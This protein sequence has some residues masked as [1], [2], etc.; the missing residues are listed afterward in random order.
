M[1]TF[2]QDASANTPNG[3]GR[4]EKDKNRLPSREEIFEVLSN[5]RR[6]YTLH[7][8]KQLDEGSE[9]TLGEIATHVA[10]WEQG[11]EPSE[12]AYDDRKSVQT[13]LYQT[14]L[15]KLEEKN[16]IEY[17][18][19]SDRVTRRESADTIDFYLETVSNHELPWSYVF[20]GLS[21]TMLLLATGVAIDAYLIGHLPSGPLLLVCSLVFLGASIWFAVQYRRQIRIGS[22]GPPPDSLT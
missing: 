10:A 11:R 9:A 14:H 16:L 13:S 12:V 4:G 17:Y 18:P 7:Y 19:D 8:L 5:R 3:T 6:R 2:L 15:P 21:T 22:D 20:L 1:S